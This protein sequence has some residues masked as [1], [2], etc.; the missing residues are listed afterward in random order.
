MGC[1]CK[2][3]VFEEAGK[4]IEIKEFEIPQTLEEKAILVK[5]T[6]AT[7]C[8][9]DLHTIL[10]RRKEAT[11]LILGHEIIGTVE[12]LGSPNLKDGY[13]NTLKVG[14]RISWTIMASCGECFY[15]KIGLPQKCVKLKKYGHTSCNDPAIKSGLVGGYGEYVYILPG[16]T[17]FKLSDKLSDEVATPANCALAT[18]V[19]AVETIGV[20]KGDVVLVQGAGLLGLNCCALSAAAGAKEIIITD[21]VDSRLEDARRFGAT[22]TINLKEYQGDDLTKKIKEIAPNGV[23]VA[24]EFCGR[25][26]AANQAIAV[27]RTGGRYMIAGMV[28]PTPLNIDANNITRKYLTIKGIH[29]YN[30]KHLG[31]ALKFLEDNQDKYPY[32]ELVGEVFPLDKINEAVEVSKSQKYI[33]VGIKY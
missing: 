26:E 10:G 23:D 33:R 14:D 15:C 7:I 4:P 20:N 12:K 9:S 21:V 19:N 2:A 16:T 18:V 5:V 22:Q 1:C 11:P 17:V 28:N 25:A 27:L 31:I 24:L 32:R 8:G 6:F 3:A 13:G 29:N 30:P